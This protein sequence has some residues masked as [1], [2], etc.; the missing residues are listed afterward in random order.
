MPAIDCQDGIGSDGM[1]FFVGDNET[2]EA[3]M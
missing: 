3:G 1:A 2:G